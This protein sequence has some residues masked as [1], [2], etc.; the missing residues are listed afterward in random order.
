MPHSHTPGEPWLELSEAANYLGVHF[1]T[2]RRWADAGQ[3][4][5]IR[6]PG[7]RRRFSRPELAAFLSGLHQG[8]TS[9][10]H[11][12]LSGAHGGAAA[13]PPG[14]AGRLVAHPSLAQEPWY[15]RL[16]DSQRAAFRTQ[17][18]GLMAVLMQ[19]ATRTN[20]GEVFLEEGRRMATRYGEACARA[21]LSLM[22]TL[23]TFIHVRRGFMDPIYEAG[24]L[25]GAPDADTWR[26]YDRMNTFLDA[27]LVAMLE[28]FYVAGTRLSGRA[29]DTNRIAPAASAPLL[30]QED[31][32]H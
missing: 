13:L 29:D 1:T 5:C 18:Q 32:S 12:A 22:E 28:A 30:P 11:G 25:A 9:L 4:P 19:Y 8:E 7:G 23:E 2:L 31:P 26:L 10:P 21:G 17:G 3:V 15:G 24:T 6:T 14:A 16:D 20:G 27:M